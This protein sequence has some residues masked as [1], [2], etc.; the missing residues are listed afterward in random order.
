MP[1]D[2]NNPYIRTKILTAGP[3]EL[4]LMLL[5]GFI[6]F[7]RDGRDALAR[8]E[9]EKVYENFTSARA[10]LL[11]LLNGLRPEVA[12]ELCARLQGLYTYM[13]RRLTE[14]S[15]EK[16]LAKIDEVIS[17]MEFERETW[18]LLMEKLAKERGGVAPAAAPAN[19]GPASHR[20]LSM[21]A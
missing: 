6:R 10:I 3:E 11:E 21:S 20:P 12:P 17:L 19:D 9:F 8:K 1:I 7:A 14:G 18:V 4:R 16:D 13:F 15:F 2:V 5:E